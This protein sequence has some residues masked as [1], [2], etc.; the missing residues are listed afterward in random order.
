MDLLF[1]ESLDVRVTTEQGRRCLAASRSVEDS[2]RQALEL[3]GLELVDYGT[4]QF[5]PTPKGYTVEARSKAWREKAERK[6]V[7]R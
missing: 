4:V 2:L 3:V 7:A 6:T 5:R 1:L